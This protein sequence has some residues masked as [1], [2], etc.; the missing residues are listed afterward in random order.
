MLSILIWQL[1]KNELPGID[2]HG[3][4]VANWLV[5]TFIVYVVCGVLF[6]LVIPIFIMAAV[7]IAHLAFAIIGGIKANSGEVWPYPMTFIKLF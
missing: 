3:K 5:T 1:K 6:F 7:S 4:I 2:E